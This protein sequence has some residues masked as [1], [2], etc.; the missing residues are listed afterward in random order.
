MRNCPCK[1]LFGTF[2]RKDGDLVFR[3]NRV[4][5]VLA[6]SIMVVASLP[7]MAVATVVPA[8]PVIAAPVN[9][10]TLTYSFVTV[11]GTADPGAYIVVTVNTGGSLS[12]TAGGGG[13]WRIGRSFTDTTHTISAVARDAA[14][15]ESLRSDPVT[16][17]VDTA[18]PAP[19]VIRSPANGSSTN[20]TTV[21]ISGSAEPGSTVSIYEG[22][23][24]AVTTSSGTGSFQTSAPFAPGEHTITA[25]ATDTAGHV[26]D[27]TPEIRFTVDVDAPPPPVIATPE[28]G[29]VLP[30]SSFVVT[31]TAERFATV[32]LLRGS[33]VIAI[34]A[35]AYDGAWSAR[36]SLGPGSITLRAR[37]RDA[38]GNTGEASPPR[39]FVIDA[40][41]PAVT[42]DTDNGTIFTPLAPADITGRA[43]DAYG[44]HAVTLDFYDV[45]G[46]G[47][48]TTTAMLTLSPGGTHVDWTA[49]A[50]V[51]PGRYIVRAYAFDMV[52][53]KSAPAEINV[54][55]ART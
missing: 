25:R 29:D 40:E 47:V 30:P 49:S 28:E 12:T 2:P 21:S 41:P 33:L 31:G 38:A 52:G 15:N 48:A 6:V 34:T 24:L 8:T 42:I 19:P 11:E 14:G 13:E 23:T 54:V 43:D 44:I 32:Q 22:S 35:A 50:H 37:A 26:S 27:P 4:K 3:D 45:T 17:T 51:L 53:N 7:S 16:F 39:H 9:G 1:R 46:R 18:T 55:I 20:A 36:P 10:S 5:R